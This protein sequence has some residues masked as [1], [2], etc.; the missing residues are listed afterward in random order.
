MAKKPHGKPSRRPSDTDGMI[1]CPYCG[2]T[3]WH[4]GSIW[5]KCF[6]CLRTFGGK[7]LLGQTNIRH[8]NNTLEN[9][10]IQS[11]DFE[12]FFDKWFEDEVGG[13]VDGDEGKGG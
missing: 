4:I 9:I 10:K 13:D 2:C 6:L 8:I 1:T 12:T 5:F 11:E 3:A 7:S